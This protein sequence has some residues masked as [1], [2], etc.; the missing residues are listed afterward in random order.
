MY[1]DKPTTKHKPDHIL[2]VITEYNDLH[3]KHMGESWRM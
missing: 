2:P 3:N 1:A